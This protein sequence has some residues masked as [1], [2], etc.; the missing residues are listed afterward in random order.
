MPSFAP[1]TGG[2]RPRV[3]TS[4]SRSR[5]TFGVT[6]GRSGTATCPS[7]WPLDGLPDGVRPRARAARR[8]R[9]PRRPFTA[10]LVTELVARG[11]LF[12]PVVL[13][14]GLSSPE[15]GEGPSARALPRAG[16]VCPARERR[17]LVG[18]ARDRGRDD[19]GSRSRDG[20]GADGTVDEGDGWSSL[21][22]TPERGLRAVDGL[23]T[24]W[25]EPESS[26]LQLLEAVAGRRAAR[27]LLP[28]CARARLP[29]ARVRRRSPDPAL[30]E[31]GEAGPQSRSSGR[32]RV[33]LRGGGRRRR[34]AVV[35][36]GGAT[37]TSVTTSRSCCQL[38]GGVVETQ[39][40]SMIEPGL[41]RRDDDRD[42]RRR[43]RCQRAEVADDRRAAGAG[44]LARGGRDEGGLARDHGPGSRRWPPCRSRG[45]RSSPC[46]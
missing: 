20:G 12:A 19:G 40:R 8:C 28:R 6:A 3:S 37:F 25:H 38:P 13:H 23:L 33:L 30:R 17:P 21:V 44:A 32:G 18:W 26:H 22:V 15:R 35:G 39:P 41:G 10:E 1:A 7:E 45:C 31:A 24:G 46:R 36:A 29:L 14:T 4:A 42:G 27:A 43:A 2:S 16:R 11:V 5:T 34:V 9:A